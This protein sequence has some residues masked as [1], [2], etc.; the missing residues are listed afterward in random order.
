MQNND[1]TS[2][3]SPHMEFVISIIFYRV[4]RYLAP[5]LHSITGQCQTPNLY[6]FLTAHQFQ[7]Y[8]Q[9][10]RS[11]TWFTYFRWHDLWCRIKV[12]FVNKICF[13]FWGA[14]TKNGYKIII[15]YKEH[16]FYINAPLHFSILFYFSVCSKPHITYM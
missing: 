5:P 16:Y 4:S 13:I 10:F 2:T 9:Y 15:P 11:P 8:M 3:Y 6:I 12:D 7:I 1:N 14:I